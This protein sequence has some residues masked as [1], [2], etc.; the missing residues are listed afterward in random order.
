MTYFRS[1]ERVT[2][3]ELLNSGVQLID[4]RATLDIAAIA[5][6]FDD[7]PVDPYV[8]DGTR[9]KSIYRAS[10]RSGLLKVGEHDGLYQ[11]AETN[12]THGGYVRRYPATDTRLVGLIAPA[13]HRF[14]DLLALPDASELLVQAQ[15]ITATGGEDG[16]SGQPAIEGWH[17][18]DVD[19]IG[20]LVVSR[21]NITG[22]VTLLSTSA[23]VADTVL[24]ATLQP[25]E[26]LVFPDPPLWHFT[27]RVHAR[28]AGQPAHRDVVL[29]ATPGCR[30]QEP[31]LAA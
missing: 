5:D 9:A 8:A 27:S 16:R 28:C 30:P 17:Q 26:M 2:R 20:I 13:V 12:P 15:R 29:I 11:S 24:G 4:L 21:E 25:G 6:L 1:E 10:R 19:A 23:D 14:L 31:A 3:P 18:D 7:V 22:G